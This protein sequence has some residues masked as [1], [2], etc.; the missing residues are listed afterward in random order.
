MNFLKHWLKPVKET[1]E[2]EHDYLL[3]GNRQK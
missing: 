3:H 1:Q 2:S